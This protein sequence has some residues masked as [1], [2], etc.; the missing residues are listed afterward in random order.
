MAKDLEAES[1]AKEGEQEEEAD[2]VGEEA[3]VE[4]DITMRA[5]ENGG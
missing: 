3:E 1:E 2:E 5:E 4:G